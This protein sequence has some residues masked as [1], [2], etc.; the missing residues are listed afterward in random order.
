MN[1]WVPEDHDGSVMVW[2]YGGGFFS[3]T[4]SLDLYS[5]SVLAA[6]EHTIVV[7]VNYRYEK[8]MFLNLTSKLC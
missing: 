4:P 3:G 7:N 1:I 6:K 8:L 2:I 5:G